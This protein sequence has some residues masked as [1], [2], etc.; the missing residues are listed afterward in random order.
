MRPCRSIGETVALALAFTLAVVTSE[1]VRADILLRC[2]T[3]EVIMTIGPG[4]SATERRTV[5]LG[6]RI[7]YAMRA[8]ALGDAPLFV[9]RFDK[10]RIIAE[11]DEVIYDL[12]RRIRA[13][14]YAGS[15]AIGATV[16]STIVGSGQCGAQP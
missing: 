7:N 4:G 6:F 11:H 2:S 15:K 13:L 10:D 14:Y 8:I 1:P 5:E 9:S 3:K 16:V 12:H